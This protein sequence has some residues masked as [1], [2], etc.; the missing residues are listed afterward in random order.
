M[1][2][3][4]IYNCFELLQCR[5]S[6]CNDLSTVLSLRT[7][8]TFV[9]VSSPPSAVLKSTTNIVRYLPYDF[10]YPFFASGGHAVVFSL[11]TLS[12]QLLSVMVFH[13]F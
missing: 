5:G 1:F 6:K 13:L 7:A 9:D 2:M 10:L 11:P 3:A 4:L 12:I 8:V